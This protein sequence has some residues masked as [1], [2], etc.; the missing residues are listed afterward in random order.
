[1]SYFVMIN[2]ADQRIFPLVDD[3]GAAVLFGTEGDAV[4]GAEGNSKA[5]A[6]GYEVYPNRNEFDPVEVEADGPQGNDGG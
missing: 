4:F 5:I 6:F 1:M 3:R 2:M